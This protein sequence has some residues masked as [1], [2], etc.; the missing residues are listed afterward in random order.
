MSEYKHYRLALPPL[1]C[2]ALKP[3]EWHETYLADVAR[4]HGVRRPTSKDVKWL[5]LETNTL[6]VGQR[7]AAGDAHLQHMLN[8]GLPR[9]GGVH[10]SMHAAFSRF[11]PARYCPYCALEDR[12]HRGR[13]RLKSYLICS[14]HRCFLKLDPSVLASLGTHA[15]KG[16]RPLSEFSEVELLGGTRSCSSDELRVHQSFWGELENRL[17]LFSPNELQEKQAADLIAWS[18]LSWS[19]LDRVAHIYHNRVTNKP[20]KRPLESIVSFFNSTELEVS[21]SKTGLLKF[22]GCLKAHSTYAGALRHLRVFQRQES[23]RPSLLSRI[24]L[25]A[26]YEAAVGARPEVCVKPQAYKACYV[27]K[28]GLGMS[29][30]KFGQ[31]IGV[32]GATAAMWVRAGRIQIESRFTRSNSQVA[33]VP[34]REVEAHLR[35]RR[36]LVTKEEFCRSNGLGRTAGEVLYASG[37]L[38]TISYAHCRYVVRESVSNLILRLELQ[39]APAEHVVSKIRLPL[40]GLK[41]GAIARGSSNVISLIDACMAGQVRVFRCLEQ[42]GLS[43]FYIDEQGLCWLRQRIKHRRTKHVRASEA[44]ASATFA[45]FK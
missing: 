6:N 10:V 24:D 39:S 8:S 16:S 34:A 15:C 13:W 1:V 11:T 14:R 17:E 29:M 33:F 26:L 37:L 31:T 9:Y 22:F 45:L 21:P 43:S 27:G 44:E 25:D 41:V 2:R 20:Y 32:S 23:A 19:L 7:E 35:F 3:D 28:D 4:E 42:P 12:Y 40:F 38:R 30:K 5:L 36:S 18:V